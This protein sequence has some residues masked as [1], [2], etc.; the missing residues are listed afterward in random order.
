MYVRG[1]RWLESL[2]ISGVFHNRSI[3]I[4]ADTFPV[5]KIIFAT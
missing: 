3:S 1:V 4:S 5:R 2:V